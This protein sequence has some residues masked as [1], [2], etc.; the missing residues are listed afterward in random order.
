MYLSVHCFIT[1]ISLF[2]AFNP[3]FTLSS[4]L[5]KWQGSA[6][7]IWHVLVSFCISCKLQVI[8]SLLRPRTHLITSWNAPSWNTTSCF[9]CWSSQCGEL[10]SQAIL[11]KSQAFQAQKENHQQRQE[12]KNSLP[13]DTSSMS[14]T[15]LTAPLSNKAARWHT[16]VRNGKD[17][18][19]MDV[20]HILRMVFV[21]GLG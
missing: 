21:K 20:F 14:N 15:T 1:I 8:N 2:R 6:S 9:N 12:M 13:R 17:E 5:I 7:Y 16:L 3:N 4:F 18:S 10:P 11:K 19:L